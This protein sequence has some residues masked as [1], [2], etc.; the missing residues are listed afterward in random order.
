MA[1]E[2][3]GHVRAANTVFLAIIALVGI[4]GLALI[5]GG[6]WLVYLGATG[7]TELELFGNSF[8]SQN[9]GVVGIFSGAVLA[10]IG[11]RSALAA[12]REIAKLP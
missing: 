1:T 6:I 10:I 12:L 11:V 9:V 3:A 5:G 8:K 4:M 7:N 2:N